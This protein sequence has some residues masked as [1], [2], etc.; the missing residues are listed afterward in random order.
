[1]F[2]G[3]PDWVVDEWTYGAYMAT[4]PDPMGEIRHHW[5][6]WL[7][8]YELENIASVGLNT[9]RIQIGYWSLIP[10]V[11]GEPFLV[12]AFEYLKLA[13]TWA[14]GLNLKVRLDLT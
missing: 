3:K 6:T 1:M 5:N 7:Q 4:Q 11:N 12:G 8:Y 2:E 10:L 13:V 9:I 14:Q